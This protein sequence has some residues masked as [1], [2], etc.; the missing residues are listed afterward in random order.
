MSAS[1]GSISARGARFVGIRVIALPDEHDKQFAGLVSSVDAA[2]LNVRRHPTSPDTVTHGWRWYRVEDNRLLSPLVGRIT[3]PRNGVLDGAYFIPAAEQMYSTAFTMGALQWYEVA[4]TFGRVQGPFALDHTMPRVGSMRSTQYQAQIIL[5]HNPLRLQPNYDLPLMV[6]DGQLSTMLAVEQMFRSPTPARRP[7]HV[8]FVCSYNV[9]RSPMAAAMFAHQLRAR[10]LGDA[11][12]VSSGG[13]ASWTSGNP[14]DARGAEVLRAN[15]YPVPLEHRSA[16]V[17]DDCL[18]AD[19]VVA[20]EQDHITALLLCGYTAVVATDAG[21]A[22][23]RVQLLR[24]FDP[25][26]STAT[27]IKN[28]YTA[29]DFAYC[30]DLIEAA[31]PGLHRW[32]DTRLGAGAKSGSPAPRR[33]RERTAT[34]SRAHATAHP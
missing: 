7:L 34:A 5:A 23:D 21:L 1:P 13:T 4:L 31:L 3:L 15:G 22:P 30:F 28:P 6:N 12:R 9:G 16:Q 26:S 19:L 2:S 17:S 11:V 29:A 18:S 25:R 33:G 14:I 24:S 27:N 32:V 8:S 10:G 20:M